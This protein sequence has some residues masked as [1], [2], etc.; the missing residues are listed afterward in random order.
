[1]SP[2]GQHTP[3][4][5]LSEAAS[6]FKDDVRAMVKEMPDEELSKRG[7]G[8]PFSGLHS[9]QQIFED[10]I[11]RRK[12]GTIWVAWRSVGGV[13]LKRVTD[14]ASALRTEHAEY[15]FD[16]QASMRHAVQEVAGYPVKYAG[17]IEERHL[18][19]AE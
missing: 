4:K 19:I 3:S 13:S 16:S 8:A 9:I 12:T 18:F 15:P 17:A 7:N 14:P 2:A 5:S 6:R 1:M 11:E 10:E